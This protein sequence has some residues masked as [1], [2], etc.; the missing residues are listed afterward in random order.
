[1]WKKYSSCDG[2]SE[3][4]CVLSVEM[5]PS[6]FA[7]FIERLEWAVFGGEK[8]LKWYSVELNSRRDNHLIPQ[9]RIKFRAVITESWKKARKSTF[10]CH[11]SINS[12]LLIT[13]FGDIR[14]FSKENSSKAKKFFLFFSRCEKFSMVWKFSYMK[15]FANKS[16]EI[17]SDFSKWNILEKSNFD[18]RRREKV[19]KTH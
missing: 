9:S 12:I 1:M 6:C 2:R 4:C 19:S 3:N 15:I 16:V 18:L 13:L 14:T 5:C 11:G 17:R 8:K 7:V 10:V